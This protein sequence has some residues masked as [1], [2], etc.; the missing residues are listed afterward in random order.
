MM[1]SLFSLAPVFDRKVRLQN[2][3][4]WMVMTGFFLSIAVFVV[5]SLKFGIQRE[6][7]FEVAIIFLDWVVLIVV[8]ILIA[9]FFR[10][11]VD[12]PGSKSHVAFGEF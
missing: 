4:R 6:Y 7:R 12:F 3:I 2:A 10:R 8:G 1:F 5:V 11:A 9:R